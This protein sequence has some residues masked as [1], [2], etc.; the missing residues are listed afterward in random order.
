MGKRILLIKFILSKEI[1][2][3]ISVYEPQVGHNE[4]SKP[5]F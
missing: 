1:P 4:F 3:I 2:N 5:Q